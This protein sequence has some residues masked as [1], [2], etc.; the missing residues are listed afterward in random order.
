MFLLLKKKNSN[1]E[2][3]KK[4]KKLSYFFLISI[5]CINILTSEDLTES[6]DLQKIWHNLVLLP[7]K[8]VKSMMNT[9]GNYINKSQ[10]RKTAVIYDD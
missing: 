6:Q 7:L 2:L 9:N 8:L 4:E 3:K 1:K 10:N 5:K